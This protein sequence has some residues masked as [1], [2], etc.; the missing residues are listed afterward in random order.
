[1][2]GG[3][4]GAWTP[5]SDPSLQWQRAPA[6]DRRVRALTHAG[7]KRSRAAA[8]ACDR[9]HDLNDPRRRSTRGGR[10]RDGREG[11]SGS[12][13]GGAAAGQRAAPAAA[14]CR[15]GPCRA[16][17]ARSNSG[18]NTTA[19]RRWPLRASDRR[20][21]RPALV[22]A[23][24][25]VPPRAKRPAASPA[26]PPMPEQRLHDRPRRSSRRLRASSPPAR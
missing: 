17:A 5:A 8:C 24:A 2:A 26:R 4:L 20:T 6:E 15:R 23:A 7:A 14:S 3:G 13:R 11:S 10:R 22:W 21:P 1:M 9:G 16:S 18:R 25:R 12:T 19:T